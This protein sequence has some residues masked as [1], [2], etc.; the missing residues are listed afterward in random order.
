MFE[1]FHL[2]VE[3]EFQLFSRQRDSCKNQKNE[4]MLQILRMR[5]FLFTHF[6]HLT[7]RNIQCLVRLPSEHQAQSDIANLPRN[8]LRN[9]REVA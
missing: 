1:S 8:L 3:T 5:I 9:T 7:A 4:K 2:N 6:T